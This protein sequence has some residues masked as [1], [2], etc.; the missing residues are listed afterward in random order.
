MIIYVDHKEQNIARIIAATFPDYRGTKVQVTTAETYHPENYWSGGTRNYAVAYN[1]ET[2][3]VSQLSR[4]TENPMNGTAHITVGIPEGA[5]IVEHI[6]FQGKDLGIRI[7]VR[8]DN[9]TPFLPVPNTLTER[10][11]SI[12]ATIR[13]YISS[14]RREVFARNHVTQEEKD[15]LQRLG[16]LNK[17]NALTLDGKNASHAA[18]AW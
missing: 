14:Y 5:A 2:G 18:R 11:L 1:L 9:L 8:P 10:Q 17:R 16:Y 3:V 4:A 13:S 12:L 6:L 7:I 15:E